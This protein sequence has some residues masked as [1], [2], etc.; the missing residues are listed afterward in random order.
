[1]SEPTGEPGPAPALRAAARAHRPDRE[2]MR[3]RVTAGILDG[4]QDVRGRRRAGA[5]PRWARVAGAAAA[6]ALTVGAVALAVGR[7]APDGTGGGTPPAAVT[8]GPLSALGELDPDSHASWSQSN[9]TVRT[10]LPLTAFSLELRVRGGDGVRS[11]GA[12]RTLPGEDFDLTVSQ[13]DEELVHRWVL[14][15]GA[16]VPAGEHVFAAQYDHPAGGHEPGYDR[17]LVRATAA[18][19]PLTAEGGFR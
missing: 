11:T 8:A 1:M 6:L 15:P 14:R 16:E 18:D 19:G 5:P 10:E 2:R 17:Y 3:A 9:V 12:W 4:A 7:P 13:E